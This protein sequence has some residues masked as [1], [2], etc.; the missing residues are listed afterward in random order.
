MAAKQRRGGNDAEAQRLNVRL[1]LSAY[2][3]LQIH[4]VM[5]GLSPGKFLE[6]L[7]N[8]HCKEWRVQANRSTQGMVDDRL[9][10]AGGISGIIAPAA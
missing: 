1:N 8:T 3:R 10:D 9:D 2:Q 6:G 4:C 7:I 5:A